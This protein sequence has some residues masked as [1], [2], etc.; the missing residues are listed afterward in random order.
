MPGILKKRFVTGIILANASLDVALHDTN[1]PFGTINSIIYCELIIPL[2]VI[3]SVEQ[4]KLNIKLPNK[5]SKSDWDP[6]LV[7]L[8]DG[9]GSIQVN[10]WQSKSLQFRLIIKLKDSTLNFEI[11]STIAEIYGGTIN[12]VSDKKSGK[13]F[14]VWAVNDKQTIKNTIIPLLLKYKPLTT[15]VQLQFTFLLECLDN[16]TIEDY[17]NK[18]DNKYINRSDITPTAEEFTANLPDYFSQW[19]AGFIEAEGS[20]S[21]RPSPTRQC[22]GEGKVGNFSFSIAQNFDYH[23]IYAI[24]NFYDLN[25]LTIIHKVGKVSNS[26]L[27]EFSVGSISGVERV[28]NHC[29]PLLQGHK[30]YQLAI[31]VNNNNKFT[32]RSHE[33]WVIN[34]SEN[35]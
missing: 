34:N 18:R 15:R 30:Y 22:R 9:D 4:N 14:V 6:F 25:H 10:H 7:G 3:S 28:I 21:I 32:N 31:F 5:L 20:F 17:F 27:Y 26:P 11:L 16:C 13:S 23:L 29:Q 8:I 33:F 1:S 12:K 35:K 2:I 24:R 19:L